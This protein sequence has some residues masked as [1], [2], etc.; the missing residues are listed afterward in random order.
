MEPCIVKHLSIGKGIPKVCVPIIATNHQ[1]IIHDF[2]EIKEQDFELIELRID[3]FD[4]ILDDTKLLSLLEDIKKLEIYKPIIFTYRSKREGGNIQLSDKQYYHLIELACKSKSVDIIDIEYQST[5]ANKL[6]ALVHQYQLPVILSNHDFNSTPSKEDLVKRLQTMQTMQGD[7]LKIAVMPRNTNDVLTLLE[8]TNDCYQMLD[9]PIVTMSMAGLGAVSRM[10]GE[11][12][13][14][15][16]TFAMIGKPSA[17]GQIEVE[18][19]KQVL[20]IINQAK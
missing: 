15:A 5:E 10:M 14:S 16:I 1:D 3:F 19:L 8:V 17:P 6:I 13:G 18:K 9:K 12:F 20:T 7:I 11:V 2:I 4:A